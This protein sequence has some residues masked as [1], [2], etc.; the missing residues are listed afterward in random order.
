LVTIAKTIIEG[1]EGA[2]ILEHEII[3]GVEA[4]VTVVVV[5]AEVSVAATPTLVE[6]PRV[7]HLTLDLQ[8]LNLHQ[9]GE[10]TVLGK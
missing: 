4:T 9:L 5:L 8:L 10:I 1:V 3:D 7:Q 2:R 6:I